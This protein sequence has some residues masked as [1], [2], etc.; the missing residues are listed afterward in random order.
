MKKLMMLS[1]MLFCFLFASAQKNECLD[2]SN[3][4]V[5]GGTWDG[6]ALSC[7]KGQRA[8]LYLPVESYKDVEGIYMVLVGMEKIGDTYNNNLCSVCVTYA[9]EW[10]DETTSTWQQFMKGKK[11]LR[12]NS[13]KAGKEDEVDI[14]PESIKN[15]YV[16][17]GRNKKVE[18][19]ISLIEKK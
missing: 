17:I 8:R 1:A 12:F 10:G 18:F 11:K 3:A 19:N 6:K 7:S 15:V 16:E 14:K 9:D 13:W 4:K 2:L 5:E